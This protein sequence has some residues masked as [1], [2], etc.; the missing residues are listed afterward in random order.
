[1]S[2]LDTLGQHLTPDTVQAIAGQLG[3]SPEQTQTA[4]SAA[5]PALLS[6]LS[7]TAGQGGGQANALLGVLDQDGDGSVADEHVG[8]ETT[9]MDGSGALPG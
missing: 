6:G 3:A 4:V 5:V 7:K 2:L 8:L 1:M 9:G